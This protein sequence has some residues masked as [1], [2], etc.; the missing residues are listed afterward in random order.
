M[1]YIFISSI[2]KDAKSWLR[3]AAIPCKVEQGSICRCIRGTS[4]QFQTTSGAFW[5]TAMTQA[6]T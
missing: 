5:P 4:L 3:E 1:S 6:L 2:G